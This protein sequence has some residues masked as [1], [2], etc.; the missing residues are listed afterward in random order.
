M[1]KAMGPA[2]LLVFVC[3]LWDLCHKLHKHVICVPAAESTEEA[4]ESLSHLLP[5]SAG[6]PQMPPLTTPLMALALRALGSSALWGPT[7]GKDL[8]EWRG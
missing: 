6:V 4:D 5:G 8:V 2:V 3:Q 1:A 7:L